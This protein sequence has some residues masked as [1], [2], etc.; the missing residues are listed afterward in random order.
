MASLAA[1]ALGPWRA[2]AREAPADVPRVGFVGLTS[3][4]VATANAAGAFR[5]RLKELGYVEG[6]DVIVEA[7]WAEGD[8]DR[9]PALIDDLVQRKVDVIVTTATRAAVVAKA[10]T[11]TIPIVA[12]GVGDP[13]GSNLVP[14]LARP[15]GNLTGLSLGW[16]AGM[17]GKWLEL[18]R[19]T[20]PRLSVVAAIAN[21]DNLVVVDQIR[22]LQAIVASG[23]PRIRVIE[24][25]DLGKLD[26]AFE[27]ARQHA[28]AVLVLP[29]P[30]IGSMATRDTLA[31]LAAKHRLPACYAFREF[32]EAGGL[33]SY[34]PD[35]RSVFRRAAEY[36][37]K[38][39]KGTPPGDLPVEQPTQYELIVNLKTAR[40][41]GLT[42]PQSIAQRADKVIQ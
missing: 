27:E 39:L 37:D 25:R 22:Q 13:V 41:L 38:I 26:L 14:N 32:V 29:D 40:A 3:A 31:A 20:V 7:R 8:Y 34:G 42:I 4:S 36:V 21:P 23:G 12:V 15:G 1:L 6:R 28:Q 35:L 33:M 9:L 10:A 19:D 5:V 11:S 17:A 24:V 2:R 30:V 16:G 18:L